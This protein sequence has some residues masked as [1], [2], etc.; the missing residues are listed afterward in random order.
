M[1]RKKTRRPLTGGSVRKL[2]SIIRKQNQEV[3]FWIR[4]RTGFQLRQ[5]LFYQL[6]KKKR[7]RKKRTIF[8]R[9]NFNQI[10]QNTKHLAELQV[11][12]LYTVELL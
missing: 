6:I 11:N 1:T 10:I 4:F 3:V 8:V 7:K 2:V 9:D 5:K 12:R